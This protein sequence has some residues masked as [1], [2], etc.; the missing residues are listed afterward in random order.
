MVRPLLTLSLCL[1]TS[2]LMADSSSVRIG[3]GDSKHGYESNDYQTN[4]LAI[5]ARKGQPTD[6]LKSLEE[7][8]LGLPPIPVPE[9]NPITEKKVDLGKKLFFDRRLSL[10]NTFSCAMCHVPEQ[11]FTSHE[12][13]K[14]VGFEGRSGRRNSPTIYNIA[15]ATRLFHDA[16]EY[17]LED[18]V[19]GPL[20]AHNE[21]AMTS[22]GHV[23]DKIRS[24]DEY[25]SLFEEAFD[26]KQANVT[27]IGKA[28]AS[29]QRLLVSANSAFDRFYYNN[30]EDAISDQA[31]QGFK[32]FTGKANCATCHTIN[33]DYS[34]FTDNKL[35]NT[36]I[37]YLVSMGIEPESERMLIAPGIY[38]DVKKSYKERVAGGAAP[39]SDLGHYE[40]TQH[41]DDRWKYRTPTLR[42]VA[43]TGP[44][45]HDGSL[46]TLRSVIEFYNKGG[47]PNVTS[48]PLIKPL[49][50]SDSEMNALVAFMNTLNGSNVAEIISD[51]F[52]TPVG[53]TVVN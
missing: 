1:F 47:V 40:V 3:A 2:A 45:M 15:Y 20:L 14:A 9:Q 25:D 35:H 36:G 29:Y 27:T 50:L 34:L 28:L 43:L 21:M 17:T 32:L 33:E 52:S 8:P 38:V 49:N 22:I 44:Y 48:S 51:A 10:N 39:I 23:V 41:P 53:D 5:A 16:R 26:G 24:I 30:E 31:K 19:W 37:G 13:E 4:S 42:N 46:P 18:Q 12:I 11:G 7:P 6:L